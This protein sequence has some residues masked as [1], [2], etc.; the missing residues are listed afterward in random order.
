MNDY[1]VRV[2]VEGMARGAGIQPYLEFPAAQCV[3]TW[4][5][6]LQPAT[7]LIDWVTMEAQPELLPLALLTIEFLHA[8]SGQVAHT[9]YGICKAVAPTVGS[10]GF[11]T[12]QAFV[13]S[14]ELL[15]W[16]VMYCAFN[17]RE[18]R[19]VDDGTGRFVW[20]RR[21]WHI[22]PRDFNS[23][24]KTYTDGPLTAIQIM[25]A[26]FASPTCESPW[27]RVY[28][29][30]LGQ[31]VYDFDCLGGKKLGT[32]LVELSEALGC[33]FTLSGGRYRLAWCVRGAGEKPEPPWNSDQ[34]RA[35]SCLSG[36]STR[37]RLLGERNLYEV[38][39]LELEAD[40]LPGWM[41]FWNVD[42]L[43]ADLYEH[44]VLEVGCAGIAAGTRYNAIPNDAK[45]MTGRFLSQARARTIT[46][47]AY[48]DL[49]DA[50]SGDGGLFRDY[51]KFG[52]RSRLQMPAALYISEVVFRA[53]RP[54]RGYRLQN[55]YGQYLSL[56][57][58]NLVGRG[59]WR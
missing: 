25:D 13:D 58:M 43:S 2:R 1:A 48:A 29:L 7:A 35:G 36:N 59:W 32:C 19:L 14:R 47:G 18:S 4:S 41:E 40:W 49:R 6:G 53:F 33:Q 3:C 50:R 8:P 10:E 44:E 42:Y 5:W 45:Q 55:A 17:K 56:W 12:A 28:H 46:V 38:M 22:Y 57:S 24:S 31:P 51:R 15:Q 9:F 21:Y 30:A 54:P 37:V 20:K 26:L 11:S 39:N 52:G 16:D 34:R 27:Y 23:M